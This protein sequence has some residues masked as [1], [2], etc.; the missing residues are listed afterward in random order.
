MAVNVGEFLKVIGGLEFYVASHYL[1]LDENT[2]RN[3]E[4]ANDNDGTRKGS[5]LSVLDRTETP[6]GARRLRQWLFYPLLDVA[7]IRER[8]AGVQALVENYRLRQDLKRA[9][10]NVQDL[11][12]LAARTVAGTASPRDLV[13]IKQTLLALADLRRLLAGENTD[14][15]C[16]LREQLSELPEIVETHQ[17]GGRR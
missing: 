12:R 15:L 14:I 2:R 17:H 4:L 10:H 3:L 8:Q 7:A 6:M 16:V 13:A 5:L 11:E 9:L 1:V